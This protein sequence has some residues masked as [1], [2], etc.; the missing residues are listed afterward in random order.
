MDEVRRQDEPKFFVIF[1]GIGRWFVFF[2]MTLSV[3][4]R[5][6]FTLLNTG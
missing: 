1:L 5:S 2:R 3:L 4:D 6:F